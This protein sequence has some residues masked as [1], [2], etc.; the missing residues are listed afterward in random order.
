MNLVLACVQYGKSL[1]LP[2]YADSEGPDSEIGLSGLSSMLD[3]I[4]TRYRQGFLSLHQSEISF[5]VSQD[6]LL[7]VRIIYHVHHH[8]CGVDRP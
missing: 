6:D 5:I 2:V 3:M 1:V 8:V 7:S 4:P